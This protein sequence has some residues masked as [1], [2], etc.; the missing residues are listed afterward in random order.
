MKKSW[1]VASAFLVAVLA[2]CS[3]EKKVE[4]IAPFALTE[5]A[6]GRY[7]GMNVLEH[8]GPKGQ[9]ILAPANEAVWFSSARDT[10]AF[11][12]LPEEP[13]T[14]A[15]IYVSDMGKAPSWEEPGAENWVDA[16]KAFF[17][18][19]SAVLGGMGAKE[20]VPFST[21]E[22]AERFVADKGGRIVNFKDM[23]EDYVLGDQGV[24]QTGSV[25]ENH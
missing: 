2:G 23:P 7:C 15:A 14:I 16:R 3:Q 9:I 18:I 20:A 10:L 8:P 24:P 4:T 19:E 21:Q 13:K 6:M 11:T 25:A 1:L 17:V 5:T 22:A 12:M